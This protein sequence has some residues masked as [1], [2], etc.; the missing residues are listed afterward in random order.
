MLHA[1]GAAQG[2]AHGLRTLCIAALGGDACCASSWLA[3]LPTPVSLQA[4]SVATAVQAVTCW[5]CLPLPMQALVLINETLNELIAESKRLVG[6]LPLGRNR[7]ARPPPHRH[8][9]A[10]TGLLHRCSTACCPLRTAEPAAACSMAW[11]VEEEDEEF[12]EEFLSKADPSI[13]HFLIA[14]GEA[15]A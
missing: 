4:L 11:Q 8:C 15:L 5:L 12:V 6:P 10:A 2:W 9:A 1:S 14:S 13:L 7:F 3:E